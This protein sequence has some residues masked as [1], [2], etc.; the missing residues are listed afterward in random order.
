MATD[1]QA[2]QP[3]GR[4][5]DE[6]TLQSVDAPL[7]VLSINEA[8]ANPDVPKLYANAFTI[9]RGNSDIGIYLNRFNQPEAILSLSYTLAKTLVEHLGTA[10]AE[11]EDQTG[12]DIMTT[13]YIDKSTRTHDE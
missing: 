6:S 1:P 7:R 13:S 2:D 12:R 9:F 3:A 4:G 10:I 8:I 5:E 11:L